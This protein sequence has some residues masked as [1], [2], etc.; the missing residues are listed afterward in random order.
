MLFASVSITSERNS[1]PEVHGPAALVISPAR[2]RMPR[3]VNLAV[4]PVS[5]L[6]LLQS[7][8]AYVISQIVHVYDIG[9]YWWSCIQNQELI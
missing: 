4:G 9:R 3:R 5:E 6:D 1:V 8:R 2:R 7:I